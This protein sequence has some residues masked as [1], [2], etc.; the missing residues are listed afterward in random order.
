MINRLLIEIA[1]SLLKARFRQTIVAAVGVAF[2][3]TMF[4]ALLSFMKGLNKLLDGLVINRTAHVRI[5]KDIVPSIKQP[6]ALFKEYSGY[7]NFIS[8]VKATAGRTDIYNRGSIVAAL[9]SDKRVV[10]VSGKTSTQVFFNSG[11]VD[12]TGFINGIDVETELKYYSFR[13]Y[14]VA[15]NPMDLKNQT[16]SI[17][18][19]KPLA[20]K[21]LVAIGDIVQVTT[22]SGE[23]MRLKVVGYYQS[24]LS[25]FD[26]TQSFASLRTVQSVLG[27]PANYAT[28][29]AVRLSD[30]SL[31]PQVA[32]E[33]AAAFD[34]NAQDIQS[35]NAEFET[36][37][38]IRNII[39]YAVGISLLVVAGFGIY[40]ILNMM[41]FEKMDTIAILKATG[42]SG[43]DVKKIFLYISMSI[44]VAGGLTGLI[45]GNLTSHLINHLPFETASIPAIRTFPVDFSPLYYIIASIF[46]LATTFLAGWFPARK[47]SRIDPV[48]IIRGK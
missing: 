40:N 28:D 27:K 38:S 19:G 1:F 46:S 14:V 13:D 30:M 5:F 10:A 34:V 31:A 24:G 43:A 17:I 41:I 44:G 8:S 2:S 37:S 20:E 32:K 4:V 48:V 47:A 15:G 11:A 7:Y 6:V 12:I 29:I 9:H 21:L 18:L 35:A 25:D 42:F 16:S 23:R 45:L 33:Y 22:I 36:G 26:K 3:I 39:S